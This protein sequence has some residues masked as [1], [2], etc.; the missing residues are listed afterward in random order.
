M[1]KQR[2]KKQ[3]DGMDREILRNIYNARRSLTSRQIAE[4]VSMS[5]GA[6]FPRLENLKTQGILK[7][8][9]LG[10][11]NFDRIFKGKTKPVKIKAP[12]SILWDIDLK[13]K[14]KKI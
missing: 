8:K 6:I 11:R 5:G 3:I 9:S 7:S 1:V 13:K 2:K 10:V 12:R 4:K 14:K